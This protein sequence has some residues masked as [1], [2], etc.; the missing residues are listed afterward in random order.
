MLQVERLLLENNETLYYEKN[1]RM[2]KNAW[3]N[4]IEKKDCHSCLDEYFLGMAKIAVILLNQVSFDLFLNHHCHKGVNFDVDI[5][6]NRA[7]DLCELYRYQYLTLQETIN[8]LN[9]YSLQE[10]YYF[11]VRYVY[12]SFFFEDNVDQLYLENMFQIYRSQINEI[13]K[14]LSSQIYIPSLIW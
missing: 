10:K 4:N 13:I 7:R 1:L 8:Q 5:A 11:F 9:T 12:P 14:Y 3:L 2:I 6:D